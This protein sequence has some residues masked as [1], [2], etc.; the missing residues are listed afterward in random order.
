MGCASNAATFGTQTANPAQPDNTS[1]ILEGCY[2][3]AIPFKQVFWE[4][5]FS[6]GGGDLV[7]TFTPAV[8]N[9]IGLD[10]DYAVWDIGNVA[11]NP[12]T[13]TCPINPGNLGGNLWTQIQCN[14]ET[15]AGSPTG[16]G[17]AP[18]PPL[19]GPQT[20]P[21]QAGHYYAVGI[22]LSALGTGP[23]YTF[24]VGAATLGGNPMTS[25][26]CF[27]ILLP[28]KLSSFGASVNNCA[29]N[30]NWVSE[31]ESDF[32]NYQVESSTDGVSFNAVATINPLQN[33]TGSMQ[34]YSYQDKTPRQGKVYYRLKMINIDGSFSYSSI[35]PL[36][37][38]C[39]MSSVL[40][41]PNPVGDV[42]NVNITNANENST[43]AN[44][45]DSDGRLLLAKK[46]MSGTN[47]IDMKKF[48]GGLYLLELNNNGVK[49]HFKIIK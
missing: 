39:N 15:T 42:L 20:V 13:L 49:Q 47:L 11:P 27:D 46:L 48:P 32:K 35:I 6:P 18:A 23:D 28:L 33:N 40:I 38:D 31:T 12:A 29:V 44:L 19:P 30:L 37:L 26:N 34:R 1:G 36:K 41:Y 25:A 10:L 21:T 24:T 17:I 7:Q 4:F 14:S 8:G 22:I 43:N 2:G 3:G 45:F 5:F 9:T 16:P